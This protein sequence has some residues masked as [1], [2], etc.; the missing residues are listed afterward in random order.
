LEKQYGEK[1]TKTEPVAFIY[2]HE[3][4]KKLVEDF[5]RNESENIFVIKKTAPTKRKLI[6]ETSI[7]RSFKNVP[8]A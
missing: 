6:A 5:I 7:K 2:H 1:I 4:Q 3:S 8:K